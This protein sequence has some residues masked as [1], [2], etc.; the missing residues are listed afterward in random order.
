MKT[1]TEI[2]I[3]GDICPTKDTV[4]FFEQNDTKGMFNDTLPIL[5][6]AD[7]LIGNMEFVLTDNGLDA[8]KIGPILK[9]KSSY[10]N[11]FRD[12]GFTLLGLANNHIKDCGEDGVLNSL[13]TCKNNNILT[14]GA[15]KNKQEAKKPI[16]INKNGWKIGIM[17]FAEH[18]F[19]AAYSNEAG[20]NLLDLYEDFDNIK[21]LKKKVDYL[22]VLYH[23][24]IEH[25][26]YP[27]PLLQKKCRKMVNS[28][29]NYVTCQHSHL[30]GTQESYKNGTILYG[31][32]NT[33][34]GHRPNDKRWNEGLL[35]K[36]ELDKKIN[37]M[38]IPVQAIQ[39]GISLIPHKESQIILNNI[40][41]RS[42]RIE[43]TDFV[44]NS[45]IEFCNNKSAHYLPHLFGLSRIVNKLNRIFNNKLIK[46]F[47]TK[48]QK[49]I[50]GN[51]IRCESHKEMIQTILNT[52]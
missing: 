4:P 38:N 23:G 45:W 7:I 32:G 12:V 36:I 26:E 49:M 21:E 20:A 19:N 48:N 52:K 37:M 15:G 28:G 2:I 30:I 22:I 29:A 17:A 14:I 25:Y 16:I 31:Q 27:S 3:C 11:I 44:S 1:K 34:F 8:T 51:L 43:E 10:I 46:C 18:E 33:I 47:F 35:V 6:D 40:K 50:T 5:Q 13:H 41:K 42:E 24:G 9:G 39:S